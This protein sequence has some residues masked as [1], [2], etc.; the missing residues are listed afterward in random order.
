[1]NKQI[2]SKKTHTNIKIDKIPLSSAQQRFFLMSNYFENF[3]MYFFLYIVKMIF[4]TF[5]FGKCVREHIQL[6][7]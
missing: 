1:M 7:M 3:Y 2:N 5:A 6:K 4:N